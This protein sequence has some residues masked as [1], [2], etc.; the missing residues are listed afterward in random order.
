MLG[1][2]PRTYGLT[3]STGSHPPPCGLL[4]GLYHLPRPQ[5]LGAAR[6]V[7]EDPREGFLLIAQS[8]RLSHFGTDG[9]K[10]VPAYGAVLLPAFQREHSYYAKVRCSTD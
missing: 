2:E 4:S 3:Y 10:G 1:L 9:S 5:R 6:Q 8:A 7:S